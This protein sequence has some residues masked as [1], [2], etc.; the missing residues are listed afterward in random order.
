MHHDLSFAQGRAA[1][2]RR[3]AAILLAPEVAGRERLAIEIALNSTLDVAGALKTLDALS[4]AAREAST[5]QGE[6]N[7]GR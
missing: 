4:S 3:V 7:D 1:E 6:K 2:R 5:N